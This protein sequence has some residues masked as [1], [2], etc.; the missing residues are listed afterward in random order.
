MRLPVFCICLLLAWA[1]SARAQVKEEAI[2][3][4]KLQAAGLATDGPGLLDF[5]RHRTL[6]SVAP[7]KL[8]TLIDKLG[9]KDAAGRTRAARELVGLGPLA[10]PALRLAVSDPDSPAAGAARQCLKA[11]SGEEAGELP[12]AAARVLAQRRPRGAAAALLA[13]LPLADA[14]DVLDEIKNAL[15]DVAFEPD[16]KADAA[17]RKALEDSLPLRRAVAIEVL[18]TRDNAVPQATLRKLLGDPRPS[19]RLRA[20]L[21]LAQVKDATAVST[22]IALLSELPPNLTREAEDF[23]LSLAAEQSPKAVIGTDAASKQKARDLW[24]EWWL[25]SEKANLL[26]EFRKRTMTEADREK[27]LTLIRDLSNEN[28]KRRS[29]AE[30]ALKQMGVLVIPLLRKAKETESDVHARDRAAQCLAAIEKTQTGPLSPVTARLVAYRKPEGA[31][32]VLLKFLPFADDETVLTEVQ[33]ALNTLAYQDG[34]PAAELVAALKDKLPLRR[35]AAAEALAHAGSARELAEVRKL[36]EDKENSVRLRAALAL[37]GRKEREAVPALIALL[38]DLPAEQSGPAEELL[39]RLAGEDSPIVDAGTDDAARKKRRAAWEK[40]W[41]EKSDKV[42]MA[43]VNESPRRQRLL[44]LTLLVCPNFAKIVELGRDGKVRWEMGGLANVW[45]VQVLSKNRLLVLESGARRLTE[46]T[47]R[48]DILWQLTL[49]NIYPTGA[50][51]LANG[52]I[53]LTSSNRLVEVTRTGREVWSVQRPPGDILAARKFKDGHVVYA[54]NSGSVHRVD[55]AGK[56]VK[57]W[58]IPNPT[59]QGIHILNNGHIVYSQQHS[60]RVYEV[61][62]SG[63]QVWTATATNPAAV[64]R[65]PNGNTL[66][67]SAAPYQVVELD[68]AGKEVWKASTQVQGLRVSRR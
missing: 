4:L 38:G 52:N 9:D 64:W 58:R 13:Y 8:E 46:R 54:T 6:A 68:R 56:E 11:L 28:F 50:R 37:A 16:G 15:A 10:V 14:E 36:L 1:G 49:N 3:E 12:A 40:W 26:D 51:R 21:A 34:K 22:L 48:G 42:R 43:A 17:V 55:A 31:A 25:K 29:D 5:F 35:A 61:D 67:S 66:V 65:L 19:V 27:A 39:G 18:G 24:A 53:F 32:G 23:L 2:D 7:E 47:L 30:D 62:A 44:G 59:S 41:K 63:R 60:N 33:A 20:A 57:S 45:D